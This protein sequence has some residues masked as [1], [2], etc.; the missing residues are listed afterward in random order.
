MPRCRDC[1]LFDPFPIEGECFREDSL[2]D[3]VEGDNDACGYFEPGPKPLVDELARMVRKLSDPKLQ[4]MDR[5]AYFALMDEAD[6]L[7]ECY[8]KERG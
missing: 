4:G 8:E 2:G 1:K 3:V 7:L 5:E 6:Y